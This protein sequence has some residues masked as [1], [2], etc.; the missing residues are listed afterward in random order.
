MSET[1]THLIFFITAVAIAT[2][3][4]VS[5]NS[6]IQSLTKSMNTKAKA[7]SNQVATSVSIVNDPCYVNYSVY[8]KNIGSTGLA[9]NTTTIFVNGEL[10]PYDE[11]K[12]YVSGSWSAI[13]ESSIWNPGDI[14]V[15]NYS[16]ALPLSSSINKIRVVTEYGVFDELIYSNSSC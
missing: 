13:T 3:L 12:L 15:F 14:I 16:S 6:N 5:L 1:F 4:V 11:V 8:V 7:V 9:P 10:R 2:F